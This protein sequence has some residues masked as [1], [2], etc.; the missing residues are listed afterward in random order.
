MYCCFF[1]YAKC[2]GWWYTEGTYTGDIHTM[3]AQVETQEKKTDGVG[4]NFWEEM[5]T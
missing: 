5:K 1:V 3:D 2:Y 4:K